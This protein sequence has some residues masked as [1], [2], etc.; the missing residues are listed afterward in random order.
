M[1]C[2]IDECGMDCAPGCTGCGSSC[3]RGC[4]GGCSGCGS[5]GSGCTG[6][7]GCGTS[8]SEDCTACT[9]TCE[10]YCDNGCTATSMADF[11]TNLGVNIN[12]DSVIR[13]IDINE[14][15]AAVNQELARRSYSETITE[16]DDNTLIAVETRNNIRSQLIELGLSSDVAQ[17]ENCRASE[18][19]DYIS[20][21]KTLYEKIIRS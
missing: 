6:C 8:C 13:K 9:G 12:I 19:Q 7:S 16:V 5:C 11:Y 20:Y 21:I 1:A 15:I 18:M 3:G 17:Y 10:G 4:S 2:G 14:I